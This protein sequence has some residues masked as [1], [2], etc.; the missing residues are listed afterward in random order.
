[1]NKFILS[2]NIKHILTEK[3]LL[4]ERYILDEASERWEAVLKNWANKVNKALDQVVERLN[5]IKEA[6]QVSKNASNLEADWK[7]I[8]DAAKNVEISKR[9]PDGQDEELRKDLTTWYNAVKN[10][11]DKRP[12]WRNNVD[13]RN[14]EKQITLLLLP[15]IW[16]W[17]I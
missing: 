8:K 16:T 5:Q 12:E 7:A 14:V 13:N 11:V 4:D 6:N 2:E 17:Q 3:Y 1:M 9:N 10:L 15:L